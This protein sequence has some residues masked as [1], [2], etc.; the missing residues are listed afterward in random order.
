M[1]AG[2]MCDVY[3]FGWSNLL[4][5][6]V[7][8]G[9]IKCH[10]YNRWQWKV[11]IVFR[12]YLLYI[13]NV[14]IWS[15]NL[16]HLKTATLI[17]ITPAFMYKIHGRTVPNKYSCLDLLVVVNDNEPKDLFYGVWPNPCCVD[18]W[19]GALSLDI[20]TVNIQTIYLNQIAQH[21]FTPHSQML[22]ESLQAARSRDMPHY[23]CL[24][25]V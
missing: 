21:S 24:T 25:Q 5:G 1:K 10:K 19:E 15:S 2:V 3:N 11:P 16:V 17:Y 22:F 8:L 7:G 20:Q 6:C 4:R 23:S 14:S 13:T 9:N 12:F 18:E